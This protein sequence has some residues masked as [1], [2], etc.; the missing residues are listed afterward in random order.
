MRPNSIILMMLPSREGYD[1]TNKGSLA[2]FCI[3]FERVS[4]RRSDVLN[5]TAHS[6]HS[7]EVVYKGAILYGIMHSC[8]SGK[9]AF[10]RLLR[11][12][13]QPREMGQAAE[14][15]VSSS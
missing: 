6:T 15:I 5:R 4:R 9:R 12:Q 1:S 7:I 13:L 2:Y 11:P 14:T 10:M 3:S 8:D